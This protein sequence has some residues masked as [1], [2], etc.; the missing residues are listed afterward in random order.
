[1]R[2]NRRSIGVAAALASAWLVLA[3]ADAPAFAEE[4]AIHGA[5]MGAPDEATRIALISAFGG[6]TDRLVQ[7]MLR[8]EDRD[9]YQGCAVINGYRYVMGRLRGHGVVVVL[10]NPSIVNAAMVTQ[11]TL[12]RFV[13]SHVVFSG[14]A[15]GIGG[16]GAND[17]DAATANEAPLG[18]VV[19]PRRW[20]FHQE[21]FFNRT[22]DTVPCAALITL[23]LNDTL[24][25]TAAEAE[26][27]RAALGEGGAPGAANQASLFAPDAQF[28]FLRD[29]NV[30][31]AAA[32][33]YY[34][35]E[36]GTQR[37]RGV[38]LPDA[39]ADP[40]RD[41]AFRFWFEVDETLFAHARDLDVTLLDCVPEGTS[42][43]CKGA[44]LD[45][46]PRVV[47]GENG[48]SGPAFVDNAPYREFLAHV[49]NFDEAGRR[50]D[51]TDVLV[52]D[53]ET[54]AAA[55]VAYTNGVP[56]IGIRGVSDLAGAGDDNAAAELRTFFGVA[57]ENQAR[58]VL[59]LLEQL[60]AEEP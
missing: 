45:P 19:I 6:E 1:M 22:G 48:V 7:E 8:G 42:D 5:C 17:D 11:M 33:Q 3:A 58:T 10:T 21:S 14:I 40:A 56:F 54:A 13:V 2:G 41:Q 32:P 55:Q 15:G 29:T 49:L 43:S 53:M 51:D 12:D 38:P 30:T 25:P 46:A 60:D 9:A 31:S 37:L 28:P 47:V 59:A 36:D 57:A 44:P 4:P 23:E 52:V 26:S 16:R 24:Q 18:T 34:L 20:G 35:D 27:C 39:A 50:G